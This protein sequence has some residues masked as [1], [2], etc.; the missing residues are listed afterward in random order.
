[1][2]MLQDRLLRGRPER[3]PMGL[4]V[5]WEQEPEPGDLV[6]IDLSLGAIE[7]WIDEH[8][9]AVLA[10]TPPPLPTRAV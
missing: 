8:R 1:M 10:M 4:E 3:Q 5:G 6:S 2:Q 7:A 9:A